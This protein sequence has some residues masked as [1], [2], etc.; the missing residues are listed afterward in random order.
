MPASSFLI[1]CPLLDADL[2][3]C[4][5]ELALT[6]TKS[7]LTVTTA[8]LECHTPSKS[9]LTPFKYRSLSGD[10]VKRTDETRDINSSEDSK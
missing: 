1:P 6:T 8:I 5:L 4:R 7:V 9:R 2:T 3:I 10:S